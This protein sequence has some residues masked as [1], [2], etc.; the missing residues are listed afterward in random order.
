MTTLVE[1]S[2]NNTVDPSPLAAAIQAGHGDHI[3]RA[4]EYVHADHD[5]RLGTVSG[6]FEYVSSSGYDVTIGD[7]EF[8]IGGHWGATDTQRTVT[9]ASSTSNQ[10]VYLGVDR[11]ASDTIIVGLDSAFTAS[12]DP[13]V[14]IHEF[15]TDGSGVT[16]HDNLRPLGPENAT[17]TT[18]SYSKGEADNRFVVADSGGLEADLD[19]NGHRTINR[20]IETRT[21]RPSN[22]VNWQEWVRTDTDP[23]RHEIYTPMGFREYELSPINLLV[24]DFESG[25]LA[26]YTDSGSGSVSVSNTRPYEGTY[27]MEATGLAEAASYP[28]EGLDNYPQQGDKWRFF[29]NIDTWGSGQYRFY[30]AVSGSG[31]TD[32]QEYQ[33]QMYQ[34]GTFRVQK[35]GNNLASSAQDYSVSYSTDQWYE[36]TVWWDHPD[37]S[38]EHSVE[39]QEVGGNVLSSITHSDTEYNGNKGIFPVYASDNTHVFVDNIEILDRTQ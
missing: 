22:P 24:D 6:A 35:D 8:F 14:P 39:L 3:S 30:Y 7:G 33:I 15:D 13:R 20:A 19:F 28:G 38:A 36:V 17:N 11:S 27:A 25:S 37:A 29:F 5:N 32:N 16:N 34:D 18:V 12:A 23:E 9:L 26:P 10:T 21:D 1:P 2:P 4:G 31:T